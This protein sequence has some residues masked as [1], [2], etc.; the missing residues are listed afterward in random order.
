[1]CR[2]WCTKLLVAVD[3]GIG[4]TL[5]SYRIERLI[6]RGGMG[7]VYEAHDARLDRPVAL[8]V[9]ASELSRDPAFRARFERESRAAALLDHPHVIP[10]YE[11]GEV[12]GV[13]F[14]AMRLVRGHDLGA[15]IRLEGRLR[16]PR[17]GAIVTQVASA[18]D[19]A[20]ARGLIHRDVKPSNILVADHNGSAEGDGDHAYL[21]DFGLIKRSLAYSGG[22]ATGGLIGTIGYAAPE[23]IRGDEV[24]PATDVYALGCVIFECL[25]GELPFVRPYEAAVLWAHLHDEVPAVSSVVADVPTEVDAVIA[26]ALAKDP[27]QRPATCSVLAGEFIEALRARPPVHRDVD[28]RGRPPRRRMRRVLVASALIVLLLCVAAAWTQLG[29]G[30][31]SAAVVTNTIDR[32]DPGTGAVTE[33]IAVGR[34]PTLLA[35]AP[36]GV[37][38]VANFDDETLSR[39]DGHGGATTL[40]MGFHPTGLVASNDAVWVADGFAG[41]VLRIDPVHSTIAARIPVDAGLA[42]LTLAPDGEVWTTNQVTGSIGRIDQKSN[43][44]TQVA[45]VGGTPSAIVVGDGTAWVADRFGQTVLRVDLSTMQ[46]TAR[47]G[48]GFA[49]ERL[50]LDADGL[51]VTGTLDDEVARI[52]TNTATVRTTISVG[53]GPA[54]VLTD[55]GAVW[56]ANGSGGTLARIDPASGKVV[57]VVDVGH[58]PD[59]LVATADGIWFTVHDR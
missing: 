12:D 53:D 37:L 20:H 55:H 39:V 52:D 29:S 4:T 46:V 1:L 56:V 57:K 15:L 16:P 6:G 48:L 2:E 40:G 5:G 21:A 50:A 31:K 43:T 26:R 44:L 30:H 9:L 59:A 36:D 23:Q 47:I 27:A 24:S 32:L 10:I 19:A 11:A 7:A 28:D 22:P 42:D 38:W 33:S 58:D 35:A 3:V 13:L 14:L 34:R 45:Q 51:W 17:S 18:L 49:A 25:T 54:G 41:V 8:K